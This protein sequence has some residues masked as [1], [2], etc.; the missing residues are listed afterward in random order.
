VL[1]VPDLRVVAIDDSLARAAADA[2]AARLLRG[3]DAIGAAVAH[4]HNLPLVRLDS[5][6]HRRAAGFVRVVSP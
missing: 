4:A 1:G 3:A 2:A 6:L 5:E